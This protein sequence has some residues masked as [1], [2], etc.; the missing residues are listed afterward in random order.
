M[1]KE[2]D[3]E[4]RSEVERKELIIIEKR[5]LSLIDVVTVYKDN[6]KAMKNCLKLVKAERA[7]LEKSK[8]PISEQDARKLQWLYADFAT[9]VKNLACTKNASVYGKFAADLDTLTEKVRVELD[10]LYIPEKEKP[11]SFTEHAVAD[12]QELGEIRI[13]QADQLKNYL[14]G[15]ESSK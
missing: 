13:E 11:Q 1:H 6:A 2:N 14:A 4:N 9:I 15:G 12:A 7:A 3:M 5:F 10:S 8:A